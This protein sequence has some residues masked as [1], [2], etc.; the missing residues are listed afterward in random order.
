[1][2]YI[3]AALCNIGI[4]SKTFRILTFTQFR[5]SSFRQAIEH[6]L[7]IRHVIPQAFFTQTLIFLILARSHSA[8]RP[9]YDIRQNRI[10]VLLLHSAA[11]P[12]VCQP[13][14]YLD[15]LDTLV[16]PIFRI[17][18]TT[19]IFD[20]LLYAQLRILQLVHS[21]LTKRRKP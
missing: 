4:L 6:Q 3:S 17:T 20:S 2:G 14:A 12:F 16:D 18:Q 13:F 5:C 7:Y 8:P 1:M 9:R 15:G 19:V 21:L 10:I 11:L